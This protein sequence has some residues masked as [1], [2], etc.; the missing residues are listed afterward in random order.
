MSCVC[1]NCGW[2]GS[3]EALAPIQDF[4]ERMGT[5]SEC[6]ATSGIALMPE[7]ECPECGCLAY[8]EAHEDVWRAFRSFVDKAALGCGERARL[9]AP[10]G[11]AALGM[12]HAIR[13]AR[14]LDA[15]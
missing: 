15:A 8:F 4:D 9:P 6:A 3:A 10:V 12:L 1:D 14:R 7:G 13:R 11:T 5:A 2:K